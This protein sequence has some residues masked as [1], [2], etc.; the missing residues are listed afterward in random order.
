MLDIKD[1]MFVSRLSLDKN[2]LENLQITAQN[3]LQ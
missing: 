3:I 1:N 2:Q